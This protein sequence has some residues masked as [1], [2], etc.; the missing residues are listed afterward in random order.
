MASNGKDIPTTTP[1]RRSRFILAVDSN[2]NDLF[3]LSMLLQRFEYNIST[4]TSGAEA[5]KT[6]AIAVPTLVVAAMALSDM[7]GLELMQR[8]KTTPRLAATPF[9]LKFAGRT[10]E[11]EEQCR[12]AGAAGCL[13][14]PLQAENL[15]QVVQKA[16]EPTP[17]QNI[18]IHTMM[19]VIVN[20]KPLDCVE[21]ECASVLSEH[22]MYI[23]T[24]RPYEVHTRLPV[25]II[26]RKKTIA[27]EA[28]VLYCHK[29]GEGPF[30]EPGMGVKFVTISPQDQ[31]LIREFIREEVNRGMPA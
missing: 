2:A 27:V 26:V 11:L 19:P 8:F 1:E 10:P 28:V 23:R 21:G 22:G 29:F 15:Y 17:R 30:K 6:S 13:F 7:T 20:G 12:Q 5:M 3:Y 9:L 16:I 24:L 14:P 31:A 4:A 25:Q 18:R